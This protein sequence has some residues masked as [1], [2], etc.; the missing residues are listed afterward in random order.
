MVLVLLDLE[1][2]SATTTVNVSIFCFRTSPGTLSR[3]L[4]DGGG[5]RVIQ[6]EV[7][8]RVRLEGAELEDHME[9]ERQKEKE[10]EKRFVSFLLN[11]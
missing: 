6:V 11:I 4:V 8:K 10:K 7:K 1:K 2:T 3:D 5:N 9:K